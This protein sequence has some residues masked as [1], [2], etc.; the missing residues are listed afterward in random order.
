M[1]S[2]PHKNATND[3]LD[4]GKRAILS[5]QGD[6]EERVGH[7]EG[8]QVLLED[9]ETNRVE[10]F[11]YH[12]CYYYQGGRAESPLFADIAAYASSNALNRCGFCNLHWVV[13]A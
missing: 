3:S 8:T 5:I 11:D 13:D 1:P 9:P 6:P 10:T 12:S 7:S 4:A 2:I